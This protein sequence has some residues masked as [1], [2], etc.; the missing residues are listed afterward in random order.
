MNSFPSTSQTCEPFP[1]RRYCGATPLTCCPGP[2]ASVCVQAGINPVARA[3][4][5]SDLVMY[6]RVGFGCTELGMDVLAFC[7]TQTIVSA[8]CRCARQPA[9]EEPQTSFAAPSAG[10]RG[11]RE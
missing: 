1:L 11:A 4:S 9:G 3:Y 8:R 2:L 7:T 6:G 5:S 10:D